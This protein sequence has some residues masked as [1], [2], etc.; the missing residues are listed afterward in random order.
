M[1]ADKLRHLVD[2][3]DFEDEVDIV[4]VPTAQGPE[5]ILEPRDAANKVSLGWAN[6]LLEGHAI[7]EGDCLI[8][9]RDFAESKEGHSSESFV[10]DF[11]SEKTLQAMES[12]GSD[13]HRDFFSSPRK[14][15]PLDRSSVQHILL[16][17][18]K[19]QRSYGVA[20]IWM[21]VQSPW[22][23]VKPR[24]HIR[25]SQE[26]V[27]D[28]SSGAEVSFYTSDPDWI[29][30]ASAKSASEAGFHAKNVEKKSLTG[31]L[32]SIHSSSATPLPDCNDAS[33]NERVY[34]EE[35]GLGYG[36]E[37]FNWNHD[38]VSGS[39]KYSYELLSSPNG[40]S[41][42]VCSNCYAFAKGGVSFHLIMGY[43]TPWFAE[44]AIV[45]QFGIQ[46]DAG[47]QLGSVVTLSNSGLLLLG[48]GGC[49]SS[50]SPEDMFLTNPNLVLPINLA[51]WISVQIPF[52]NIDVRL[53]LVAYI[54]AS[55]TIQNS[56]FLGS[57]GLSAGSNGFLRF[58]KYLTTADY[59]GTCY[60]NSCSFSLM[61]R[62]GAPD[63]KASVLCR[64][65]PND[66]Y[67]TS[68]LKE[69]CAKG[70]C[71]RYVMGDVQ[72]KDFLAS[73]SGPFWNPSPQ[74]TTP[75]TT[76][77]PLTAEVT[78]H[79]IPIVDITLGISP[80]AWNIFSFLDFTI[81]LQAKLMISPTISLRVRVR[82][83]ENC[84]GS[85]ISRP[86]SVL[87][88]LLKITY[89]LHLSGVINLANFYTTDFGYPAG[90]EN[91][92]FILL[93]TVFDPLPYL[94]ICTSFHSFRANMLSV[95]NGNLPT[96]IMVPGVPFTRSI[97]LAPPGSFLNYAT[98]GS[99]QFVSDIKSEVFLETSVECT[100]VWCTLH[101]L[102][103]S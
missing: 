51:G 76:I 18:G 84:P 90:Y 93:G 64:Q 34:C 31:A 47:M 38:E 23:R 13:F 27:N 46:F 69:G 95:L 97:F 61:Q 85:Q 56:A 57:G 59:S 86:D 5:L 91:G 2:L 16:A 17:S 55:V 100:S 53:S 39:A 96:R 11:F 29:L 54:G 41:T 101:P 32:S 44:A 67:S 33:P 89:R 40:E 98:S 26:C 63:S 102:L 36:F 7:Q 25:L 74:A 52:L 71:W 12:M 20:K 62:C 80:V 24:L 21:E 66:I 79:V 87:F 30:L 73:R 14:G 72:E 15:P 10:F 3:E 92:K 83:T 37:V 9:Y 42:L 22:R 75:S 48:E 58:G 6:S 50:C 81:S 8:S 70:S 1:S 77:I 68:L 82:D 65:R 99:R 78:L 19:R 28:V 4:M 88:R 49:F 94:Y 35:Y 60:W 103:G 45:G 43:Y